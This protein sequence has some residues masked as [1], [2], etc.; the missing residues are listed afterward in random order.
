MVMQHTP[1]PW[2]IKT[3]EDGSAAIFSGET[4]NW[5]AVA[6]KSTP[7]TQ[8]ANARLIAAAPDMLLSLRRAALVLAWASEQLGSQAIDDDYKI[9][10]D[11]IE[12]ATGEKP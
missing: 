3:A 4:G 7:L 2:G 5:V 12:K 8:Q 10:S 6:V 9:V 11:A 1:G